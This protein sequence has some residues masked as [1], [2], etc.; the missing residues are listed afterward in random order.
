MKLLFISEGQNPDYLNDTIFHGLYH[1]FG[2]DIAHTGEMPY[3]YKEKLTD[4]EKSKIYGKGFTIYGLLPR[5]LNDNTDIKSKIRT[6]YFDVIIYGNIRRCRKYINLVKMHYSKKDIIFID[7]EDDT[8]IVYYEPGIPYFKRELVNNKSCHPISF[9]IPEEKIAKDIHTIRKVS[10]F[11]PLIPYKIDTY[12]YT[13]EDEYYNSYKSAYFGLTMKKAGWD[14][15]RHYEILAN[16]CIPYFI[17]LEKCPQMT[18]VN[19]P[20]KLIIES[21][22]LFIKNEVGSDIYYDNLNRLFEYTKRKLKTTDAAKYIIDTWIRY[23]VT[24]KAFSKSDE[25]S[26][27]DIKNVSSHTGITATAVSTVV[28]GARYRLKKLITKSCL[29]KLLGLREKNDG[30]LTHPERLVLL[31]YCTEG[32]G[33][34]I[35]CGHRKTHENCIGVDIIPQGKTGKFGCVAGKKSMADICASGDDLSM[36]GTAELDFIVSRHNLEHYVDVVKTL[37]EWHRILKPN[38]ILAVVLPDDRYVDSIKLDPTHKHAFTPE[39]FINLLNC[40]G[41]YSVLENKI[42]VNNWSFVIVARKLAK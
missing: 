36:F 26:T 34:D 16:Y 2:E 22:R 11:A 9:S 19:F 17:D 30:D 33:V 24:T 31:P 38:G 4:E 37:R 42:A 25:I 21:R 6:K 41:S 32:K 28:Q 12:I 14:C 27:D 23:K 10:S 13:N 7:G 40:V 3:M 5:Y 18:M 39:S 1:L 15:L 29:W 20:K 35:G 8:D